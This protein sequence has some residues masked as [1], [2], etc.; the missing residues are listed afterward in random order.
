MRAWRDCHPPASP[1]SEFSS[2]PPPASKAWTPP[3]HVDSPAPPWLLALSSLPWPICPLAPPGSL[4][5]LSPSGSFISSSSVL[6]RSG[7]TTVIWIPISASDSSST[8]SVTVG[9]PPGVGH[10]SSMASLHRLH[11][12]SLLWLWP[13]SSCV[14]PA[15]GLSCL[16]P[17]FSLLRRL[18]GLCLPAPSRV[19]I[20][21]LSLLLS[22]RLPL[23]FGWYYCAR[24]HLMGEGR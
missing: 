18:P 4:V 21:L 10:S 16:F 5:P 11:R 1:W 2:T 8:C 13:G 12:G 24:T 17:G 23:P 6:C 22:S 15:L 7:S 9:H 14:P 20:L 19:S 3:R